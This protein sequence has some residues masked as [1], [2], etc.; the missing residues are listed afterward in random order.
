MPRV[1]SREGQMAGWTDTAR[2]LGETQVHRV[3]SGVAERLADTRDKLERS[4]A[5]FDATTDTRG[6][7]SEPLGRALCSLR[8]ELVSCAATI[9]DDL[10]AAAVHWPS[11]DL[12]ESPMSSQDARATK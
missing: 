8:E 10:V 6:D 9:D 12:G 7:R 3:A 1:R 11:L 2:A 4:G 5:T